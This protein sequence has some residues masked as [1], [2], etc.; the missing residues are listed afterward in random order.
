MDFSKYGVKHA[1][2]CESCEYY[3][4]DEY[5]DT[6]GCSLSLDED[7]MSDFLGFNTK[8]CHYYKFY[9]EYKSVHRQI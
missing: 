6:Y 4:Y 9:D 7:E 5:T 3:E 2:S 8:G 1:P